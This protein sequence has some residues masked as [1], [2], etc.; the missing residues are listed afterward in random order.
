[1]DEW[2]SVDKSLTDQDQIHRQ[3]NVFSFLILSH[4][5]Y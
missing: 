3:Y 4:E 5:V 2:V 1:M